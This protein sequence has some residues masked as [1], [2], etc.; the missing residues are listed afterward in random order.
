[1]KYYLNAG[2]A[3]EL[4]EADDVRRLSTKSTAVSSAKHLFTTLWRWYWLSGTNK[5]IEYGQVVTPCL[6]HP[7]TNITLLMLVRIE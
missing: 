1:M 4:A 5:W 7:L 6:P 2:P 3:G